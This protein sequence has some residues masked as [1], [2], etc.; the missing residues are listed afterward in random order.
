MSEMTPRVCPKCGSPLQCGLKCTFKCGT[1]QRTKLFQSLDCRVAELEAMVELHEDA[2]RAAEQRVK[3][4]LR[5]RAKADWAAIGG[6]PDEWRDD[7]E[8]YC[9]KLEAAARLAGW[10]EC[11]EACEKIA[12]GPWRDGDVGYMPRVALPIAE[13][14]AALK[15]PTK[16]GTP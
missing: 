3:D 11:R 5:L 2:I 15:P 4:E 1:Q 6:C 14:I 9:G 12:R 7:V 8:R 10:K 16:E 13:A